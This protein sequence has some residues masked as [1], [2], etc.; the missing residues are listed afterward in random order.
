MCKK[1]SNKNHKSFDFSYDSDVQIRE[2]IKEELNST[3]RKTLWS[4]LE[5][6]VGQKHQFSYKRDPPKSSREIWC[7]HVSVK[8]CRNI[9]VLQTEEMQGDCECAK[10]EGCRRRKSV[11]VRAIRKE[12]KCNVC[13]P[14]Q[15]DYNFGFPLLTFVIHD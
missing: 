15:S 14:V 5:W 3:N 6:K 9:Q 8:E 2:E 13:V 1:A 4:Y 10:L 12:N 7:V 11:F